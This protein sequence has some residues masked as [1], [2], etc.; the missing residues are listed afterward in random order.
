MDSILSSNKQF[1][2]NN[3]Y[4]STKSPILQLKYQ[5]SLSNER[6]LVPLSN[7]LSKQTKSFLPIKVQLVPQRET[8]FSPR[9]ECDKIKV[10]SVT[11]DNQRQLGRRQGMPSRP[12][13]EITVNLSVTTAL[14][15]NK[16]KGKKKPGSK[17]LHQQEISAQSSRWLRNQPG[18]GLAV[19][20]S[21]VRESN[22]STAF[23]EALTN[24]IPDSIDRKSAQVWR[25]YLEIWEKWRQRDGGG[26]EGLPGL[27]VTY[28]F[29]S[30]PWC[31]GG[32]GTH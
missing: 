28:F 26:N 13:I 20:G 4:G 30:A 32:R 25:Y 5:I 27:T 15:N 18:V 24:F 16:T 19:K 11:T 9:K 23:L 8:S 1:L 7:W 17:C 3:S 21:R 31:L 6:K 2:E 10:P 29:A 22:S 14:K 12:S